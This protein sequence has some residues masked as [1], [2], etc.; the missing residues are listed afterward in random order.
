MMRYFLFFPALLGVLFILGCG[1]ASGDDSPLQIKFN[2]KKT[3]LLPAKTKSCNSIANLGDADLGELY[4]TLVNP[5]ISWTNDNGFPI[6]IVSI[7]VKITSGLITGG[8]YT[9]TIAGDELGYLFGTPNG[10]SNAPIIDLWSGNIAAGAS[11]SA[12]NLCLSLRCG[13][14]SLTKQAYFEATGTVTVIGIVDQGDGTAVSA[15]GTATFT[16]VNDP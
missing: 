9:C 4:F 10:S 13:G 15:K 7:K 6:Q 2:V 16:L 5:T 1:G 11:K 8:E 14:I 3:Y 12:N